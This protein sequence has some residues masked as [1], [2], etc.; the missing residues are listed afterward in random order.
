[1]AGRPPVVPCPATAGDAS[2]LASVPKD[3]AIGGGDVGRQRTPSLPVPG[4]GSGPRTST[5]AE[6]PEV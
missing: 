4:T 5:A 3:D 2:A 1:M 6:A